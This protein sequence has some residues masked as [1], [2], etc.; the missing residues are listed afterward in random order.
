MTSKYPKTMEQMGMYY[1]FVIY[2]TNIVIS[3]KQS[4]LTNVLNIPGVRDR[5][6]VF[7]DKVWEYLLKAKKLQH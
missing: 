4:Q 6:I 3:T 2:R 7:I 1:G 5:A